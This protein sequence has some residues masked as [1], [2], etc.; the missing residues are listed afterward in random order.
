M[1]QSH[2]LITVLSVLVK[3][4]NLLD[5]YKLPVKPNNTIYG[6]FLIVFTGLLVIV[7]E[8]WS[9]LVL[10]F[11]AVVLSVTCRYYDAKLEQHQEIINQQGEKILELEAMLRE[12]NK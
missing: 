10:N 5:N 7:G 8:I 2:L 1:Y 4:N 3:I 12:I 9:A 11:L 6:I